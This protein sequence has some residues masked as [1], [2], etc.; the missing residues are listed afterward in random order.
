MVFDILTIGS[1]SYHVAGK[2]GT[3]R[4]SIPTGYAL[5]S[6]IASFVGFAP[7]ENPA[8]IMLVKIGSAKG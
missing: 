4:V 1:D 5:D 8:F 2:T 7:V 3:T 6:T